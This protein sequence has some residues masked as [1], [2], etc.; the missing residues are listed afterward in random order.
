MIPLAIMVEILDPAGPHEYEVLDEI[1]V[2]EVHPIIRK[3]V[4]KAE[5]RDGG[6]EWDAFDTSCLRDPF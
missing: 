1:L 5:G 6:Q 4:R 3:G 2:Y